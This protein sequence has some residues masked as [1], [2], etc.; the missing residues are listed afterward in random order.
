M[1]ESDSTVYSS[2]RTKENVAHGQD[3]L[4]L[5]YRGLKPTAEGKAA[6]YLFAIKG[7]SWSVHL[8]V[9]PIVMAGI[10]GLLLSYVLVPSQ[11][12]IE[13]KVL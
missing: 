2:R 4:D 5:L 10:V 8:W 9:G 13:Q 11:E 7:I 1:C 6:L 3:L 12:L